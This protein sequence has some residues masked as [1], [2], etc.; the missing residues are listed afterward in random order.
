MENFTPVAG[1]AGGALIGLAASLLLLGV[2]RIAG[3]SG[4]MEGVINPGN[5][6]RDWRLAF[7]FGLPIGG[8]LVAVAAPDILP[9]TE[10][11]ASW[12]LLAVSGLLVGFGARVANGCTSGHGVCGIPRMA[13]RSIAATIFYFGAAAATVYVMRHLL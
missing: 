1:F 11:S 2:G 8:I 5:E 4:V 6:R 7:L 3:I 12:P 10:V 9:L 13:S